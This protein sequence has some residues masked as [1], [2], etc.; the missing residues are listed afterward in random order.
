MRVRTG[1]ESFLDPASGASGLPRGARL[2]VVAHPASIDAGGRHLV[3]R[4]VRDGRFRIVRLFAPEH[5]VRG[6]AQDME[7][8]AEPADRATGLPVVSLYGSDEASLRPQPRHLEG[9]DAIVYDLQDVGTRY[10][11]F[12]TTLSYVMEAAHAASIPVIVLD[13]P[14]PIGGRAIEGPVLEPEFSSFVG[15]FPI[16]VRHGLTTAELA[17]LFRDAFGVACDLRIVPMTGWSRDAHFEDTGLP[18]VLPSPNMPTPDTARVYP[19]G[20]LV[21]GTNLSEGRGTTRPFELVGAPWIEPTAL[22]EAL[23]QAGDAEGLDG[24]L[25]RAAWMR[26]GFQK[27]AGKS[28][29][30]VQVHL[31]DRDRARPFATYL[32]LLREA[33]KLAPD[34]FDWRRDTYEF[35]SDRLAIDLLFGVGGLRGMV[36][37]GAPLAEMEAA[38]ASGLTA[39]ETLRRRFLVYPD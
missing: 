19:G 16:P 28:C 21:E 8:V 9:L 15:R 11:T 3:D 27:H 36:E 10:Y 37:A 7:A 18:W 6:E 29:G 32:V 25:F 38:W 35:V 5:G 33:R 23:S 34:M 39:F 13:R 12:V 17:L 1:L 26:P 14:N 31:V 22:A 30:G 20:C 24:V 4:L 2:G